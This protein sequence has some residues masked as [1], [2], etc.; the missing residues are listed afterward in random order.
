MSLSS[1]FFNFL[2]YLFIKQMYIYSWRYKFS[3]YKSMI[4]NKKYFVMLWIT[5]K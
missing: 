4:T 1:K 3:I 2:I 5:V